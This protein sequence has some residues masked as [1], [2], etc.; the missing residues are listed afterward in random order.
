MHSAE[1]GVEKN[2]RNYTCKPRTSTTTGLAESSN[3]IAANAS[4]PAV[5]ELELQDHE[6]KMMLT[7]TIKNTPV[8][9]YSKYEYPT[10][11]QDLDF[12]LEYARYT[13]PLDLKKEVFV[14]QPNVNHLAPFGNDDLSKMHHFLYS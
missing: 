1:L 7:E 11:S 4:Q 3:A 5:S 8:I 9:Q 6:E 2:F 10:T 14:P 13:T 12:S